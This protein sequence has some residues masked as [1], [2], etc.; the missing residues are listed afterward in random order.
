MSS[1]N[2]SADYS[3][4]AGSAGYSSTV[5]SHDIFRSHKSKN[6]QGESTER[7]HHDGSR[8]I[9]YNYNARGFEED[10]PTPS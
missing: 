6:H 7:Q 4:G 5:V 1:R 3:S 8:T 9:I 2:S 10:A